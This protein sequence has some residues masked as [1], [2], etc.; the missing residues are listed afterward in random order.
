MKIPSNIISSLLE[1]SLNT[2][3][4]S[5][6]FNFMYNNL[7]IK[8]IFCGENK[9]VF[10]NTRGKAPVG[11]IYHINEN[12]IF[13][14]ILPNNA[15]YTIVDHLDKNSYGKST[16]YFFNK[17]LIEKLE[18]IDEFSPATEEDYIASIKNLSTKDKRIAEGEK[19]YF[20]HLRR[21]TKMSNKM[22]EKSKN[23]FDKEFAESIKTANMTT[24]WSTEPT[25]NSLIFTDKGKLENLV[26]TTTF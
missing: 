5:I 26:K 7:E 25:A 6:K 20:S 3:F 14:G 22:F 15:Y 13:E 21:N 4:K 19:P 17:K 9:S 1:K 10:I 2:H 8:V 24:C 18:Y 23:Y 11:W 16:P 12:G